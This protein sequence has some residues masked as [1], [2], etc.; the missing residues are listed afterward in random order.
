MTHLMPNLQRTIEFLRNAARAPST[1]W[2][3]YVK[4][5][6]E[7]PRV[8]V[9]GGVAAMALASSARA[10][11]RQLI[12]VK[13][14]AD[15]EMRRVLKALADVLQIEFDARFEPPHYIEKG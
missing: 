14:E 5:M 4:A 9:E 12:E 7:L 6:K 2:P 13:P 1:E 8:N 11:V 10:I 15:A 3:S